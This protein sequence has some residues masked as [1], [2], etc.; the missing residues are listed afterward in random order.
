MPALLTRT[1]G[2][3]SNDASTVSVAR[4]TARVGHV[5]YDRLAAE[6]GGTRFE[7]MRR[8]RQHRDPHPRRRARE[9]RQA[10]CLVR[11]R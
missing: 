4:D 1:S 5:A 3:P 8:A 9:R 6:L 2:A 7:I 10:R 11:H